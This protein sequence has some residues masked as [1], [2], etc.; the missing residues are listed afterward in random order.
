MAKDIP[1]SGITDL[2]HEGKELAQAP[3]PSSY[4]PDAPGHTKQRVVFRPW[5]ATP[6]C[7]RAPGCITSR[8]ALIPCICS[9]R[10]ILML[11]VI[12]VWH[13]PFVDAFGSS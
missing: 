2:D 6:V 7:T 10:V 8:T 3:E 1:L 12:T 9:A 11:L 13:V 5:C 4:H